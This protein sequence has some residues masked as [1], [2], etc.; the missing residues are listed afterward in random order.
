MDAKDAARL[1]PAEGVSPKGYRCRAR[2]SG[3]P[4]EVSPCN[5]L[6]MINHDA[7]TQDPP[8]ACRP[9]AAGPSGRAGNAEAQRNAAR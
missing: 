1:I 2:E 3:L 7:L 9:K 6:A 4:G 8:P 5:D